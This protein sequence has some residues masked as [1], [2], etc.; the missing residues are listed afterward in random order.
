MREHL[1]QVETNIAIAETLILRQT[2]LVA[3]LELHG[4]DAGDAE[5]LLFA[6]ERTLTVQ[7]AIRDRLQDQL[8]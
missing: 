2:S 7:I 1:A 8:A 6:L 4:Q 5:K 3:E